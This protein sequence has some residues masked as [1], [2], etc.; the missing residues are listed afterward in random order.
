MAPGEAEVLLPNPASTRKPSRA[1][2]GPYWL[3]Q[4][5]VSQGALFSSPRNKMKSVLM[6]QSQ[7]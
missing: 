3:L 4:T 2:Q 1:L 6:A 5:T 7:G